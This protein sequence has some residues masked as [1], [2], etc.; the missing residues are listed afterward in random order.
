VIKG[1]HQDK[2]IMEKHP[3]S[4]Q[5]HMS[6]HQ[7][8]EGSS[9]NEGGVS[10]R[11]PAFGLTAAP[12]QQKTPIQ[13]EAAPAGGVIQRHAFVKETQVDPNEKSLTAS[14]QSFAKDDKV[15][16]YESK[17]EFQDHADGKTDY[18]G[19]LATK[20]PGTWVRYF[21]T[22]MNLLGE[23]HDKVQ[24]VDVMQA[25]G[26]K[27]FINEQ[28]STD[29]MSTSPSMKSAY[30]KVNAEEFKKFGVDGVKDKKQFGAESL[31]PK[32][33]F[34]MT[35][36][37]PY[38]DKTY[39]LD[40][41][42][43]G[44]NKYT[45]KPLQRYVAIAWGY[46]KDNVTQIDATKKKGGTPGPK[47]EALYKV[48]KKVEASL[49]GF[50]AGLVPDGYLGDALSQPGNDKLLAPLHEFATAISDAMVELAT[51]DKSSRLTPEKRKEYAGKT[52][53]ATEKDT[54]FSEWR[55]FNFEDNVAAAAAKGVRYAGMGDNHL[56]YLLDKKLIPSGGHTYRMA[57]KDIQ[58]FEALTA[59]LKTKAKTFPTPKK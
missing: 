26:S 13:R 43:S 1:I 2:I 51:T 22:G 27:N 47:A 15:R 6:G 19:N 12:I 57:G 28:F 11:P 18:I 56:K 8:L 38:F 29:D 34:A 4:T 32:L 5:Q 55:D 39:S 44:P 50:V 59:K 9:E 7:E 14:M 21:P 36:A 30:D 46:S 40:G 31:Y 42:K 10:M 35:L 24:L 53:D 17:Q 41:L 52:L 49:D 3:Q 45:G 48:H 16:N 33:G 23:H 58:D 37:L 54:L 25:V 20:S